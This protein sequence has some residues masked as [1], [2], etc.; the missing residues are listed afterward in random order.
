MR[1]PLLIG[2]LREDE[3]TA[4]EARYHQTDD[5]DERTRC[6]IVLL[7]H[8]ALTPPAIAAIVRWKARS[9]RRVIHR[10]QIGGLAALCDGRHGNPGRERTFTLECE[11]KLL[12]VVEQD[13]RQLGVHRA[14]WT[15]EVLA[16]YLAQETGIQIGEERVRHYLHCHDYAPLRPTW[17]VAHKAREDPEYAA[18]RGR[19]R[20]C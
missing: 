5:A 14:T 12:E 20:P 11:A 9:V 16:S 3:V 2:S 8:Q 17:T 6:Q 1:P 7:S 13:P 4:L 18:K 19:S 15:A 10:Y